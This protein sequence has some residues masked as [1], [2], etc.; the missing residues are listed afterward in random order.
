[1]NEDQ[2]ET[3]NYISQLFQEFCECS[4]LINTNDFDVKTIESVC[5]N[6]NQCS[7][8]CSLD[9]IK[10]VVNSNFENST[11]LMK[12]A[13]KYDKNDDLFKYYMGDIDLKSIITKIPRKIGTRKLMFYQMMCIYQIVYGTISPN[14]G[15]H[16][17]MKERILQNL[18]HH[19]SQYMN[20]L[21]SLADFIMYPEKQK[22]R[23]RH[24]VLNMTTGVGKSLTSIYTALQAMCDESFAK[25]ALQPENVSQWFND[26][27]TSSKGV[28]FES[29]IKTK[30]ELL[31]VTVI[32]VPNDSLFIQWHGVLTSEIENMKEYAKMI[33][34]KEINIDIYPKNVESSL[35]MSLSKLPINEMKDV[36]TLTF[37]ITKDTNVLNFIESDINHGFKFKTQI[38]EE[39][40]KKR[41]ILVEANVV[42]KVQCPTVFINDESHESKSREKYS[43]IK[44]PIMMHLCSTIQKVI[45]KDTSF[46]KILRNNVPY[47]K[48]NNYFQQRDTLVHILNCSVLSR[49]LQQLAC[50][51]ASTKG[52]MPKSIIIYKNKKSQKVK[53]VNNEPSMPRRLHDKQE[54]IKYAHRQAL[55]KSI[56]ELLNSGIKFLELKPTSVRDFN[57]SFYCANCKRMKKIDQTILDKFFLCKRCCSVGYCG[58]CKEENVNLQ[59]CVCCD[60]PAIHY[61]QLYEE[62]IGIKDMALP[63]ERIIADE[64]ENLTDEDLKFYYEFSRDLRNVESSS[65]FCFNETENKNLIIEKNIKFIKDKIALIN[66]FPMEVALYL[67]LLIFA[68]GNYR[69]IVLLTENCDEVLKYVEYTPF[70][71]YHLFDGRRKENVLVAMQTCPIEE[72]FLLVMPIDEASF[73]VDFKNVDAIISF[74]DFSVIIEQIAGRLMRIGMD[75]RARFIVTYGQFDLNLQ[76]FCELSL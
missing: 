76:H 46:A 26:H 6:K 65:M 4:D 75:Y 31:P 29:S 3:F 67:N 57:L 37:A 27:N 48:T 8:F 71:K 66:D 11:F 38:I 1:M 53:Y 56:D 61:L 16:C 41:K 21:P 49:Q 63:T 55:H 36:L 32:N 70:K 9:F 20:L 40:N 33:T 44:A 5:N 17:S 69:H 25:E 59:H 58:D 23:Y 19:S 30:K 62:M 34:K 13:S 39:N 24:I 10:A 47:D 43:K 28:I 15:L 50:Y 7:E 42:D 51:E 73:G 2:L 12:P 45:K 74:N 60:A 72:Y 68:L 22:L 14:I 35:T 52:H 54:V 18:D 64:N